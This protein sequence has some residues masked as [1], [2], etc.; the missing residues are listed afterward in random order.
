MRDGI[1]RVE[2]RSGQTIGKGIAVVD[3][4]TI[5]GFDETYFYFVGHL[6]QYG[7][8]KRRVLAMRY[9]P[10]AQGFSSPGFPAT[11][12][13]EEREE[14]F[15]FKGEADGDSSNHTA[16]GLPSCRGLLPPTPARSE[17]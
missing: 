8:P 15:L 5:R 12:Y 11:V 1:Y 4:D 13:S 16:R 9:A 7:R 17:A 6:A 10:R 3:N 14:E 2:F